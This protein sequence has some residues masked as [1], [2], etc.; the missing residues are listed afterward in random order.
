MQ[1]SS[2]RFR[3]S[4]PASK[5]A[6]FEFEVVREVEKNDPNFHSSAPVPLRFN[7]EE[8]VDFS[9]FLFH[10]CEVASYTLK[11]TYVVLKSEYAVLVAPA[12]TVGPT[13]THAPENCGWKQKM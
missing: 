10:F 2:V 13:Y 7:F 5:Q 6:W 3:A 4:A 11:K 8:K 1:L 12:C 9:Q